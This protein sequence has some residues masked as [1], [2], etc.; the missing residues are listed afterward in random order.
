MTTSN[1]IRWGGLAVFL[2]SVLWGMQKIGWTLFIG[3]QD[4]RAYPQP[5]ATILWVMGLIAALFI[6]VGLPA[7]YACQA[8]Q[9]G[10]L[11]LFAF[12]MVF[13]GMALVTSNA[14][15]GV[16]IQAGLADLIILA[17]E[18][19]VT[20]QEPIAAGIGFMT[21]LLLYTLGWLLFG[22]I[23][24]RARVLPRWAA[25]LVLVGLVSGF[26][27]LATNF[28]LLAMPVTELGIAWLGF[29]LWQESDEVLAQVKPVTES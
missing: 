24:L 27:F 22:L 1:L 13:I 28:S 8:R 11:G 5:A 21:T 23:S 15:F 29:A 7:L 18:A 10:R 3:S 6:L 12:A 17:E 16:F 9:T 4:P 20:V 14:Y 2:G 26:L 25:V 19:G